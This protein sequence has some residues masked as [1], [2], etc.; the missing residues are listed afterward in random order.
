MSG[1]D[2]GTSGRTFYRYITK[3][4]YAATGSA[5]QQIYNTNTGTFTSVDLSAY[6]DVSVL[7]LDQSAVISKAT[8]AT[9]IMPNSW[10]HLILKTNDETLQ[11]APAMGAIVPNDVDQNDWAWVQTYGPM[12]MTWAYT[13]YSGANTGEVMFKISGNGSINPQ[14]TAAPGAADNSTWQVAGRS[15]GSS[16]MEGATGVDEQL[17]MIFLLLRQ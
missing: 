5:I 7:E 10:K 11:F 16:Y 1:S 2:T 4:D 17:L 15:M 8:M 9:T 12:C 3:H 13:D 14:N 6:S